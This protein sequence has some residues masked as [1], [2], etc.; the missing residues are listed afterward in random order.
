MDTC[1]YD[2]E[3]KTQS[4]ELGRVGGS[5][6]CLRGGMYPHLRLRLCHNNR[7]GSEK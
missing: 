3:R 1:N 7:D 2:H 6:S 5:L 4:R